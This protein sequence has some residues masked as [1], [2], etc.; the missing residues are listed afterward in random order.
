MSKNFL[1][2]DKHYKIIRDKFVNIVYKENY[3]ILLKDIKYW[4]VYNKLKDNLFRSNYAHH[5]TTNTAWQTICLERV[6]A[7]LSLSRE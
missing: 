4:K 6:F 1:N 5:Y 2:I 7:M 3:K